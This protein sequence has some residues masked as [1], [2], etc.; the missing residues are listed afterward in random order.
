MIAAVVEGAPRCD[1]AVT[2]A[3][4]EHSVLGLDTEDVHGAVDAFR[5]PDRFTVG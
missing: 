3:E 1:A 4:G 2:A 5:R